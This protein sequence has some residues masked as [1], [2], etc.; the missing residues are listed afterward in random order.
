MLGVDGEGS[1]S[2]NVLTCSTKVTQMIGSYLK[3]QFD[4]DDGDHVICIVDTPLSCPLSKLYQNNRSTIE[5]ALLSGTSI[6]SDRSA[7]VF[8]ECILPLP[9]KV[10]L[11]MVSITCQSEETHWIYN[12]ERY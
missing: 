11:H 1:D 9:Q 2:N 3:S 4:L 10:P 12:E 7:S 5:Q 8:S 6:I